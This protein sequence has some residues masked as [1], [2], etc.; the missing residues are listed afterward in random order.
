MRKLKNYSK[1]LK[2]KVLREAKETGNIALVADK[3]KINC[4]TVYGW[5]KTEKN[6]E[7]NQTKKSF[8]ALRKELEEKELENKI[9]KELLKKTTATLIKD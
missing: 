1:E 2:E 3:Y 8:T 9:L 5:I 7:K 4:T 6:R